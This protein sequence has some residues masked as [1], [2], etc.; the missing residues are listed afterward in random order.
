METQASRLLLL[1]IQHAHGALKR[2]SGRQCFVAREAQ[3]AAPETTNERG[4]FY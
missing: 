3:R 1:L 4:T 2:K